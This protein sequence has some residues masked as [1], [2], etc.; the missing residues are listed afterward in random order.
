MAVLWLVV[1][2]HVVRI[3]KANRI[4]TVSD[5]IGSRYGKS[6]FLSALIAIVAVFGVIPYIGLQIKA[7]INTF[8]IISGTATGS[9]AAGLVITVDPRPVR[10]HL[11]GPEPRPLGAAR[12]PR[13]RHRLRIDRQ[14][15][16]HSLSSASSSPISLFD[17]FGDIFARIQK[18]SIRDCSLS[19]TGASTRSYHEWFALLVPC[20]MM[21]IM[22]LP[23]QFHMAVVEN[24]DE[25]HITKAACGSSPS[26]CS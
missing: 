11:R 6:V 21:A 2:P 24:Y 12:R 4:T 22:F 23:R 9:I 1:L 20:P 17:G 10:R 18:R 25:A 14:A 3:S 13:L 5:F 8:T 26:T 7:I 16:R 15:R 19:N